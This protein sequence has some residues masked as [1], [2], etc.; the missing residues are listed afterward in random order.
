MNAW[1]NIEVSPD[2]QE[3]VAIDRMEQALGNVPKQIYKVRELITR[4]EVCHFK[5]QRH[6]Q[7]IIESIAALHPTVDV[8]RIGSNHPRHGENAVKNDRTGRSLIGQQYISSL[9]FWPDNVPTSSDDSLKKMS[10]QVTAWLGEKNDTKERLVRQLVARLLYQS[11][12][13]YLRGGEL[14]E[15][16]YHVMATDIC[17]YS[18]PQNLEEVIQAIGKLKPVIDFEGCGTYN[19]EIKSF[20]SIEFERLSKWLKEGTLDGDN[21]LG[22]K[23]PMKSWLVASLAK[24]MKAQI[25]LTDSLPTF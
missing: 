5:Y 10:Q 7:H 16:E 18:F 22:E 20:I 13:D 2:D 19:A 25:H 17:N 24:T 23:V 3:I 9:R 6:Y 21:K 15:L 11:M 1:I 12:E 14:E 4:F 8:D